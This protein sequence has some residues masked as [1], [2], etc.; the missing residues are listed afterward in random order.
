MVTQAN[1]CY[2][3]AF[4]STLIRWC[5]HHTNKCCLHTEKTCM[6]AHDFESR[7]HHMSKMAT[8]SIDEKLLNFNVGVLGHID[9]GKTSLGS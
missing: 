1:H 6:R 5:D 7:G 2:D 8:R 3:D 4:T 9:S